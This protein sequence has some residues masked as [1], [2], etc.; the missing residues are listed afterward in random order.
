MAN[1]EKKEKA[2]EVGQEVLDD[3]KDPALK[4]L[5]TDEM[6]LDDVVYTKKVKS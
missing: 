4:R 2:R 5:Y 3:D 6:Y 1:Q